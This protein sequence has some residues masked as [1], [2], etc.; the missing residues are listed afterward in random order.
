VCVRVCVCVWGGG[1]KL[2]NELRLFLTNGGRGCAFHVCPFAELTPRN[3]VIL[4]KLMVAHLLK[5]IPD[6]LESKVHY[7]FHNSLSLVRI[8]SQMN[9]LYTLHPPL[10]ETTGFIRVS[11][12]RL[13]YQRF[14]CNYLSRVLHALPILLT[15]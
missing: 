5:K 12:F 6:F 2:P 14:L 11:F 8:L 9:P 7:L 3:C 13:P 1:C 4:E 15:L 10:P